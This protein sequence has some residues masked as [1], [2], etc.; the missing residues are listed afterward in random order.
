MKLS[1]II[2]SLTRMESDHGDVEVTKIGW[3]ELE[4]RWQVYVNYE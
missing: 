1:E 2:E 4:D 3:V